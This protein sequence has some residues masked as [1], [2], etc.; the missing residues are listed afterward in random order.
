[1]M[2][3]ITERR[4]RLQSAFNEKHGI[5]PHSVRRQLSE[6]EAVRSVT[7]DAPGASSSSASPLPDDR[8]AAVER[9]KAEMLEAA[10]AL[11]FERAALL[12]D[13]LRELQSTPPDKSP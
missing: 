2:I 8:A 4:R 5:V 6:D 13:R 11:E 12:R 7:G 1:E 3:R 10:E 9:L